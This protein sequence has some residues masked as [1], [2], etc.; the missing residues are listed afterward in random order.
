MIESVALLKEGIEAIIEGGGESFKLCYQCGLCNTVCPWNLVKNFMIRR[1]VRQAQF[2]LS[3]M[4]DEIWQCA[5]CRNC[6]DRCPRGVQLI[7]IVVSLRKIASEYNMLPP[8][9]R[10][11]VAS[12]T[13]KGNPWGEK[14][15]ERANWAKDLSVK[16]FTEGTEILYFPC[17]TTCYDPKTRKIGIATINILKKAGVDFGIL[18]EKEV[19]CGESIRKAGEEDL[20]KRLAKEN[21]KSFI[22]SGVK[23]ILVSSP[24]CYH[25]FKNDYSEFMVKFDVIHIGQYLLDLINKGKL[26]ITKEYK[27]TVTFQDP[28][29]LGRHNGIYD[30]PREILK[31]IP[32][33]DLV[34]MR[35]SRENSI[36]CGGGGGRMWMETP[37]AERLSDVRLN[38]A[39]E[40]G[41][42]VL[43]TFCPYC[44]MNFEDSKYGLK[45]SEVIQIKDVTEI[46]QEVI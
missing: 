23:K 32:G 6:V 41:A 2:G 25:A 10:S 26:K 33:L 30:Q 14:R 13:D 21:I 18:G 38:Q 17:C 37:K 12:L 24:H 20:F 42:E 36:C 35:N 46:L 4:G 11:A 29:Y 22:E 15:E 3:E 5:T 40:T 34:D 19:C 7:D 45:D 43:A 16:K 9:I 8:S 27:K 1:L 44:F 28:C 31:H 39:L